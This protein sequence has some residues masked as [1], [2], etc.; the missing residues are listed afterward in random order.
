MRK[1]TLV[2]GIVVVLVLIA[3]GAWLVLNRAGDESEGSGGPPDQAAPGWHEVVRE[4][5]KGVR[6]HG[7]PRK[8]P[9][10]SVRPTAAGMTP[11]VKREALEVLGSAAPLRLR[12]EE[13]RYARTPAGVGLWVVP[14]RGV[15]CMF[16]AVRM[17]SSCSTTVEAYRRGLLLQTYTSPIPEARPTRFTAL[18]I[19]PDWARAVSA[20]IGG[21]SWTI[22]IV[23]N[24]FGAAAKAPI[25]II[26]L[27]R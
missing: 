17:A 8:W 19:A 3:A 5:V 23:D 2:S 20:R 18:G 11:R 6:A 22:P 9:F 7:L 26:G 21:K 24:A 4:G 13:A 15:I 12:F 14:G 27:S 16:R 10:S 1:S 25:R